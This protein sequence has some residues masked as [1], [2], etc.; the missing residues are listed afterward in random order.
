MDCASFFF[1]FSVKSPSSRTKN[2]MHN[3]FPT[4][5]AEEVDIRNPASKIGF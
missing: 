2:G 3:S 4:V 1:F 5:K